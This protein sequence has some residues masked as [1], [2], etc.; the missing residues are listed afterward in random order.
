MWWGGIPN[1]NGGGV[2]QSES[3]IP[4]G[5]SLTAWKS[6]GGARLTLDITNP[7]SDALRTVLRVDIPTN[8]VGEVGFFNEGWWGMNVEP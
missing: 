1:I 4:W 5:P 6:I 8:A 2:I 7:L 3:S